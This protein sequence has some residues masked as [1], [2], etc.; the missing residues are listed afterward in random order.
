[1]L[2]VWKSTLG[3]GLSLSYKKKKT[4]KTAINSD[5]R[6]R[7]VETK[8]IKKQSQTYKKRG[9]VRHTKSED[10]LDIQKARTSQTKSFVNT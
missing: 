6:A 10:E 4:V 7:S 5:I 3:Q 9:R 1:M 8:I 2:P